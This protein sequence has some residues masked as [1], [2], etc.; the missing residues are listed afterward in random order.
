MRRLFSFL[1]VAAFATTLWRFRWRLCGWFGCDTERISIT[2]PAS[3]TPVT[4]PIL[5]SGVGRATQ[6]NQLAIEVR[7]A[8][9]TVIGSGV[10]NVNAALGQRGPFSAS[11]TFA[12]GMPGSP[13]T[14]QVFDSSPAT[15]AITHL[16]SVL[17]TF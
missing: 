2:S 13:G 6:H 15:G 16:A 17:V 4:S 9:N 3:G 10:A 1:G 7:D 14:V 11:V 8:S 5:V 12:G